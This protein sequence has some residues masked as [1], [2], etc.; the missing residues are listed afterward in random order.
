ML[1]INDPNPQNPTP[2]PGTIPMPANPKGNAAV[3]AEI[4]SEGFFK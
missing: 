2:G 3:V 4:E 1:K